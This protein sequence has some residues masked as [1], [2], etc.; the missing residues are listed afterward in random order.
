MIVHFVVFKDFIVDRNNASSATSGPPGTNP[1]FL[2]SVTSRFIITVFTK[3]VHPTQNHVMS[4]RGLCEYEF[5]YNK[6]F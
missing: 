3:L 2:W 5:I 4:R 1:T 6:Y